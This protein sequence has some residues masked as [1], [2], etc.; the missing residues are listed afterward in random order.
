[1]NGVEI[2]LYKPEIP[3]NTGNI[4]RLTVCTGSRLHIIDKPSFSLDESSVK[5][6]GLDYW[7]KVDLHLHENWSSFLEYQRAG[8]LE[9]GINKKILLF[10]RFSHR[11]YTEWDYTGNELLVF[12]QETSGLPDFVIEEVRTTCPECLLRIPVND[13]C[14]SLN[15][16]NSVAL[17]AYESF[18]QRGYP[19]LNQQF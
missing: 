16:S 9:N 1:M 4:G 6:A 2:A 14:R 10:T 17:A 13:D 3:Q 8:S 11:P 18:R 15:L 19:G 12:G 5:R 7:H